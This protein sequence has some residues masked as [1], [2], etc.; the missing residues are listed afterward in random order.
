MA[1]LGITVTVGD[2]SPWYHGLHHAAAADQIRVMNDPIID[3][4]GR[5][6]DFYA[7]GDGN[8]RLVVVD[9]NGTR[10]VELD[11]EAALRFARD[12]LLASFGIDP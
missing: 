4:D 10:T 7:I 2:R 3:M 8:F 5:I 11:R 1:G 12:L 6:A 9:E